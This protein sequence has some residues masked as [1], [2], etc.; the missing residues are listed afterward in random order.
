MVSWQKAI[1]LWLQDKCEVLE[2]HSIHVNSATRQF[3]L[4]SVLRLRK[5]ISPY[6]S[7]R[8]RLSRQNLFIRDGQMCQ[9]CGQKF[10]EKKLTID[11]IQPLSR[12][13]KHEWSNVVAACSPCNNKKGSRTPK[14]AKMP[15]LTEPA[16]P[17]WLPSK[18]FHSNDR[19]PSEWVPYL[20][21]LVSTG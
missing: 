4:P 14:E 20:H 10:G 9:Y 18:D 19:W 11:H 17:R 12:G 2:F 1:I 13:G 3:Q 8:I 16:R 21:R 15:L 6:F 5:Y 7:V